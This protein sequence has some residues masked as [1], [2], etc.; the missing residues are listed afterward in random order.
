MD[1][2]LI[3]MKCRSVKVRRSHRGLI[4][5]STEGIVRYDIYNLGRH[6]IAVQWN[7]GVIDY[8]FPSE[9]EIIGKKEPYNFA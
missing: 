5:K 6:L 4:T 7:G 9:I 8:V 1:T 3:G 2:R